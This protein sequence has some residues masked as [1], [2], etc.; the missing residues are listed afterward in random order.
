MLI[1]PASADCNLACDYCFYREK[2]Q[3]YP[4]TKRHRM[5]DSVLET[6]IE[7]Y[8]KTDQ[9]TYFFGWQGGE[10]TLMGTGF[11]EKVVSLQQKYGN[12]GSI[13]SNGVQTNAS[14]LDKDMASLFSQYKFLV[15][16]S[17]DGPQDIHNTFRKTIGQASSHSSVLSG[18][19]LLK[20]HRVEFNILVLVSQSNV[21]KASKVYSYLLKQGYYYQ[22]YIPCV[23]FNEKGELQPY[24]I[25][26]E[27][28]GKFLIDLFQ[29][30]YPN[31][32]Y[33]VSI[34]LFDTILEKK[35]TG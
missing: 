22:Q 3:L 20:Q 33:K 16:C 5:N 17:L 6:L 23:E 31:D 32:I 9:P 12:K 13:V 30:W 26:G 24:A 7:S 18:I 10:P 19:E 4:H 15:G 34:R 25:N 21:R 1:K 35:L 29:A 27:E 2:A 8:M 14:L 11:F 28:W